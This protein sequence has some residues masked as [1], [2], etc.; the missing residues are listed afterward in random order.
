VKCLVVCIIG[1]VS[2]ITLMASHKRLCSFSDIFKSGHPFIIS[3]KIGVNKVRSS[4][5][6]SVFSI[7]H[8][9]TSYI[10]KQIRAHKHKESLTTKAQSTKPDSLNGK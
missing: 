1:K 5:C 3:V 7:S 4:L 8:G 2:N 9:S 6:K 10:E